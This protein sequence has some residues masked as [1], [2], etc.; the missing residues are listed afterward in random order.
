MTSQAIVGSRLLDSDSSDLMR[1]A[2]DI[3]CFHHEKWDGSGNP[4]GLG[5]AD[6]PMAVHVAA[7]VDVFDLLTSERPRTKPGRWRARW[8]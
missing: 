8:I 1:M 4:N 5:G 7:L 6:I 3:A 2:P